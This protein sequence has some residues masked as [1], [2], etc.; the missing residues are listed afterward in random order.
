MR[1]NVSGLMAFLSCGFSI[2]YMQF[3]QRLQLEI[4]NF[5]H[6][7]ATLTYLSLVMTNCP[8]SACGQ[9]HVTH[10]KIL[11]PLKYMWTA[12]AKDFKF[13]ILVGLVK[14]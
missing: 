6:E 9:D 1:A 10:F 5:V 3:L 12:K 13:R 8:Q 14:Y 4:S 11:H 2:K 7:L